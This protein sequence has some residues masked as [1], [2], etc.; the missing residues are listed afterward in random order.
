MAGI[1]AKLRL[2]SA[3]FQRSLTAA[4]ND[5]NRLSGA[6]RNSTSALRG[7]KSASDAT[8]NALKGMVRSVV[9]I[10]AGYFAISRLTGFIREATEASAK[11]IEAETKFRQVFLATR[12]ATEAQAKAILN[13]TSAIQAQGVIGDEALVA[14]AAQLAT[15]KMQASSIAVLL[16]RIADMVASQKGYKAT[17]EDVATTAQLFGRAVAGNVAMLSRYGIVLS[18]AQ[19]QIFKVGTEEQR[20]A[21]LAE[22]LAKKYG[23]VNAALAKTDAGRAAQVTNAIDDAMEV[24]GAKFEAVKTKVMASIADALPSALDKALAATDSAIAG[25]GAFVNFIS[26]ELWPLLKGIGGEL[27]NLVTMFGTVDISASGVASTIKSGLLITLN[28]I[29]DALAWLNEN[30]GVVIVALSGIAG[31]FSAWATVT[32]IQQALLIK[33]A[34]AQWSLNAAMTANPIGALVAG[35]T[36]L[37]AALATVG[38]VAWKNWDKIKA[39]FFGIGSAIKSAFLTAKNFVVGVI[40]SLWDMLKPVRDLIAW[41]LDKYAA[42]ASFFGMKKIGAVGSAI[43]GGEEKSIVTVEGSHKGGLREVPHDNYIAALH[44]GERVL[45][46]EEVRTE[47]KARAVNVTVNINGVSKSTDEIVAELVPRLRRAIANAVV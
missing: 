23:G 46:R 35:C 1:I 32:A 43:G 14:G 33:T 44:K 34:I 38:Y 37:T 40:S 10:A 11:Q 7:M 15:Y 42:V 47:T 31:G 30:K 27:L 3:L 36:L 26:G 19:K 18:E 29:R 13:L 5:V 2:D 24:L 41:V 8:G 21:L 22:L 39:F 45:T 12:G 16:P 20:A 25:L 6:T 9:G 4:I 28:A 17:I